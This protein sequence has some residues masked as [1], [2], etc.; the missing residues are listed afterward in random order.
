MST[1]ITGVYASDNR[2]GHNY[3][4]ASCPYENCQARINLLELERL[5]KESAPTVR[6]LSDCELT[7]L[8]T[9]VLNTTIRMNADLAKYGEHQ[10]NPDVPEVRSLNAELWRRGVVK[11]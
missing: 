3:E 9:L 8:A 11:E 7:A 5:R 6:A 4:F 2:C 10:T 1:S